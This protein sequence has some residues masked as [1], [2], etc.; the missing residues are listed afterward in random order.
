MLLGDPSAHVGDSAWIAV[1]A[2][3]ADIHVP[4]LRGLW[5]Y[6]NG[7][8]DTGHLPGRAAINPFE[9]RPWLGHLLLMDVIDKGR[10]FR[11]RLHGTVLVQLF[12]AD[13][14]DKLVSRLALSDVERL[15]EEGRR[16]VASRDYLYIEETVVA[17]KKHAA[18]S[19]LILPLATAGA[20]VDMLMVGIYRRG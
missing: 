5:A 10:D 12:G 9:L 1:T 18:I 15:L 17:E 16:P 2:A 4:P 8:R 13:L 11:Y 14:T 3:P 19:K 6:W 7:K 20:D